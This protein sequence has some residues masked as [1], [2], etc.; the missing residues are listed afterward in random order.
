MH[1]RFNEMVTNH[2]VVVELSTCQALLD[3]MKMEYKTARNENGIHDKL[4][5]AMVHYLT[6]E[7][8]CKHFLSQHRNLTSDFFAALF[9]ASRI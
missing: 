8:L 5:R 4:P 9:V 2:Q 6:L 7:T 3:L 1:E